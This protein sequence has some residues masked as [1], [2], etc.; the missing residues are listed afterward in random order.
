[1]K[2]WI[3]AE[4]QEKY[5]NRPIMVKGLS[6]ADTFGLSKSGK[7]Y[8]LTHIPTAQSVGRFKRKEQAKAFVAQVLLVERPI[9]YWKALTDDNMRDPANLAETIELFNRIKTK[10]TQYL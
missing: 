6:Y 7:M 8:Q 3:E 9:E 10:R 5:I 1:M 2:N 4:W